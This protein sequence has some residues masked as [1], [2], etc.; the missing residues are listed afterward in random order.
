[1][2]GGDS[3]I[4]E[5]LAAAA[6]FEIEADPPDVRESIARRQRHIRRRRRAVA[7]LGVVV[8]MGLGF[9]V[10]RA[11]RRGSGAD[12]G[13]LRTGDSPTET[14][15]DNASTEPG[16][17][18]DPAP[19]WETSQVGLLATA[20]NVPLGP[21]A[22][23]SNLPA[24]DTIQRLEDGEVLIQATFIRPRESWGDDAARG[25]PPSQ[26]P[27]SLDNALTDITFEGQPEHIYADRVGA[28]VNGWNVDVLIFYGG[29][30]PTAVPPNRAQ[31]SAETRAAA[32]EQLAR[33]VP[34]AP[35]EPAP[36][37]D[38]AREQR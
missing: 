24:H 13:T 25:F 3:L 19:G 21:D 1:M 14:S 7:L 38:R 20:A 27:L 15:D 11:V 5:R 4:R 29:G 31:P 36:D 37:A 26:L 28:T 10:D 12:D 22:Q 6:A 34:P 23:T 35:T 16:P 30:D 32:Q 33:L 8:I 17:R 2:N 9:G 18:F